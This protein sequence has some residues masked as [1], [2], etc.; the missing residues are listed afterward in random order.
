MIVKARMLHQNL[1]DVPIAW[2]QI[3][4]RSAYDSETSIN[5]NPTSTL[6]QPREQ[7]CDP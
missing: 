6:R 4:S 3:G 7:G 5:A 1:Q 2:M